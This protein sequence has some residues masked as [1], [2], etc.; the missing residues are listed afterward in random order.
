MLLIV[1]FAI[2]A[3]NC[4]KFSGVMRSACKAENLLIYHDAS[5]RYV[6]ALNSASAEA[7][8]LIHSSS[9]DAACSKNVEKVSDTNILDTLC[10]AVIEKNPEPCENYRKGKTNAVMFLVGQVMK[11]MSGKAQPEIVREILEKKL[12]DKA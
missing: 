6:F 2:R 5:R 12:S 11:E 4:P 8:D 10:D 7:S 1:F 9:S 3:I